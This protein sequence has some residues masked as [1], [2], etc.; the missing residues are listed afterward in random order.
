[1]ISLKVKE[2][3]QDLEALDDDD[4]Q[5]IKQEIE[6]EQAEGA[7]QDLLKHCH[8]VHL[9]TSIELKG[10]YDSLMTVG[11]DSNQAFILTLT[12]LQMSK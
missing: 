7:I 8:N 1:M 2:E 4:L 3:I 11:F 5:K 6:Q 12:Q 10:M 9:P